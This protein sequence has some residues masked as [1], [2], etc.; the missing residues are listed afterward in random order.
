MTAL[1]TIAYLTVTAADASQP[2]AKTVHNGDELLTLVR[3]YF[4]NSDRAERA[5]LIA[6]IEKAADNSIETVEAALQRV[7]LW[8]PVN[9]PNS[10]LDIALTGGRRG[11]IALRLPHNYDA[12]K[13]YPLVLVLG[14]DAD[15]SDRAPLASV[16]QSHIIAYP[17][18]YAGLDFDAPMDS[19]SDVLA[20]LAALR[21]A[22]HL[23]TDRIYLY[24]RGAGADT[25]FMLLLMHTDLFAAA[26]ISEGT[27][28]LPYRRE[29]QPL[30]LPNLR[31]TPVHLTWT[32]PD[33]PPHT[34]LQGRRVKVALTNRSILAFASAN[35][36]DITGTPIAT[37]LLPNSVLLDDLF[38]TRISRDGS[39]VSHRFRYPAQGHAR[40][41][42]Q[43][44]FAGPVWQGDQIDIRIS[45]PAARSD[46]PTGAAD[47][48]TRVL[49]QKLARLEGRI[50]GNTI[51]IT[52]THCEAVDI[53][54]SSAAMD[55]TK[56]ITLI[57]NGKR[58]FTGAL[59]PGIA[60]L[61]LSAYEVWEFQHPAAVRLRIG[62]RGPVR[63]F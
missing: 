11:L 52:A 9:S 12:Q 43:H 1:F 31:H 8:P 45:P 32:Q 56:P 15:D 22:F 4:D 34:V 60:T 49:D 46:T 36:L 27:L 20:W 62:R 13:R 19:A 18:E 14:S 25:A 51:E 23:D 55:W 54:L 35:G 5:S 10:Q 38:A 63:P 33:L 40:F 61:L 53:R 48:T 29:L 39:T 2:P 41:L 42:Q 50:S 28:H 30:L 37:H 17:T 16:Q 6:N 3:S 59:S 44:E 21:R 26:L 47:F 58:R 57:Y 7:Q 24:G